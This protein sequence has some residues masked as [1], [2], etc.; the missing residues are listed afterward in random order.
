[1]DVSLAS[2]LESPLLNSLGSALDSK[3]FNYKLEKNFPMLSKNHISVQPVTTPSGS[4]Y[5]SNLVIKV[6]RYGLAYGAAIKVTVTGS[7][8][9]TAALT[10]TSTIGSRFFR[11]VSLR[12]HN[13][14]IQDIWAESTEARINNSSTEQNNAYTNMTTPSPALANGTTST[15]YVPL[16]FFFGESLKSALDASFVEALEIHLTVNDRTGMW[17]SSELLFDMNSLAVQAEMYYINLENSVQSALVASQFPLNNNL[18]MLTNDS[19]RETPVSAAYTH[20]TTGASMTVE[21]EAKTNNVI[22]ASHFM[23][24]VKDT[25]VLLPISSITMTSSG[26]TIVNSDRKTQI[27]ENSKLS[28]FVHNVPGSSS[29]SN[30]YSVFYG[31]DSDKT[32]ISGALAMNG[33]NAPIYSAVIDSSSLVTAAANATVEL[34]CVHD[35]ATLVSIDSSDGSIQRSLQN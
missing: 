17:G 21:L 9:P 8:A 13:R 4:V 33:L 10:R 3:P 24:R 1:M 35:T 31:M 11:S 2:Q 27:F 16:F 23:A 5:N 30:M 22:S 28:N 18:T 32:Y 6:P 29:G 12:T 26:Q 34:V 15:F 7:A 25:N 20:G 14:A 19:Y